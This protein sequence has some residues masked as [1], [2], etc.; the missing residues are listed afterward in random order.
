MTPCH[1]FLSNGYR[2]WSLA[3]PS[4]TNVNSVPQKSKDSLLSGTLQMSGVCSILPRITSELQCEPRKP[5]EFK[6]NSPSQSVSMEELTTAERV[7][8]LLEARSTLV[9]KEIRSIGALGFLP[10]AVTADE[11]ILN[12][13]LHDQILLLKWVQDNIE[14]FGGDPSQVTL[15]G[16]SAGAHSIAHHIMNHDLQHSL[17]HRAVIESGAATSRAVHP[18]NAQL[19]EDQFRAF[20]EK[21]GCTDQLS[22]DVMNCL[23]MQPSEVMTNASFAVFDQS[24]P[25]VR[26]AFQPVIDGDL[27]KQRPIDA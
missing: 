11:G 7:R 19:H 13:G 26:W 14:A 18:Y 24:N 17:F 12:L 16:L 2:Q 21:A 15:I 6:E 23:R 9:D 4:F 5:V 10:S 25:S 20:V 3:G 27:I 8:D 1:S 22:T